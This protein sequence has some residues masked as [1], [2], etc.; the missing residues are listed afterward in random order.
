MHNEYSSGVCGGDGSDA[1]DGK[2]FCE[3]V[4]WLTATDQVWSPVISACSLFYAPPELV[5]RFP[6]PREYGV[7]SLSKRGSYFIL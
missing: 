3:I 5:F 6:F 2:V 1:N 7:S 4:T